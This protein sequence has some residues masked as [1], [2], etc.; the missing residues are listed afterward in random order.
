MPEMDLAFK[1]MK[2]I[3]AWDCLIAYPNYNKP[4]HIYTD[5]SSYQM[6]VY[7]VQ[8]DKPVAIWSCK[9]NDAQLKCT[10]GEKE[11]LSIVMVLTEFCKMFLGAML[12]I[13]T[14][15]LNITTN[16]ST[17]DCVIWWLNYI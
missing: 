2:A 12:H 4:F 1:Q 16:N 6:G 9:I 8:D 10:V 7:I 14:N 15:Y 17:P 3:M 13:H 11:L 5:T